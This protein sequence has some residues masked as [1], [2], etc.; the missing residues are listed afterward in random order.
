MAPDDAGFQERD[1]L[2]AS[3]VL[4]AKGATVGLIY[5]VVANSLRRG[6]TSPAI[7]G[8]NGWMVPYLGACGRH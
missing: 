8:S 5:A 6:S 4:A 1:V 7:L 3:G 2:N